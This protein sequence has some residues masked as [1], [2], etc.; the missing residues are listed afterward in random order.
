MEFRLTS[1]EIR[2]LEGDDNPK[3]RLLSQL[4]RDLAREHLLYYMRHLSNQYYHTPTH[5]EF[6]RKLW[7]AVEEGPKTMTEDEVRLVYELSLVAQGWWR[8]LGTPT[9]P[10]EFVSEE[11]WKQE[12]KIQASW[13]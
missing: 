3:V 11:I 7:R 13:L 5:P 10:P 6:P 4:V 8:Y 9:E 1:E 12:Y 2:E